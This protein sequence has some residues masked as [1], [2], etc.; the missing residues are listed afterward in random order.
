MRIDQLNS[1]NESELSLLLYIVNVLEPIQSPKFQ[2]DKP[3]QLLWVRH[4]ALL[5]KLS[6]HESNLTDEG[7]SIFQSLMV[8]LNK[9]SQEEREDYERST[10][11]TL[12][13]SEFQF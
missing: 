8:K 7:K 12:T 13:Q 11:T 2:I 3:K 9:T 4:D 6:K 10:N 5:W 1:L